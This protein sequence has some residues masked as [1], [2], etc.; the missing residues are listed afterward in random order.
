LLNCFVV[1]FDD[2][3]YLKNPLFQVAKM[4]YKT[5]SGYYYQLL[6]YPKSQKSAVYQK[7][8]ELAP[9]SVSIE[10]HTEIKIE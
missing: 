6:D 5:K 4:Q 3:K 7:L 8:V 9:A 2:L 10:H 1:I